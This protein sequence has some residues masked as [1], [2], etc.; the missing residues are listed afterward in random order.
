M[1][2]KPGENGF[3]LHEGRAEFSAV[4][5][6]GIDAIGGATVVRRREGGVIPPEG[7]TLHA[8]FGTGFCCTSIAAVH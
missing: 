8:P 1:L 2:I 7:S 3:I 5:Y 4:F 6:K